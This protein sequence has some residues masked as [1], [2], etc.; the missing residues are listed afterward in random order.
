M[1]VT[2]RKQAELGLKEANRQKDS[3]LATLAHELRNPLTPIH[4]A[5]HVLQKKHG[6]S[7]SDAPLFDII[8]RQTEH[9][10]R[11]V[12]DLLDARISCGK[13]ELRKERIDMSAIARD[14]L[15]SCR[16]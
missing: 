8:R 14:A 15:E 12:G 16:P 3:F 10:V 1:D 2:E 5:V 7:N 6:A 4:N 13:I 11:L 9:L